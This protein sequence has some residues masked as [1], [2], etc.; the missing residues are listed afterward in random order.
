VATVTPQTGCASNQPR[1][2]VVQLYGGNDVVTPGWIGN[3]VIDTG[4][5]DD[6]ILASPQV[7]VVSNYADYTQGSAPS[8]RVYYPTPYALEG[9]PS[10]TD[11]NVFNGGADNDVIYYDGSVVSNTHDLCLGFFLTVTIFQIRYIYRQIAMPGTFAL[12]N[13]PIK[14]QSF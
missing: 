13:V 10:N 7:N 12:L 5:G 3:A 11:G 6:I 8:A 4:A 1:C 14:V 9:T 2:N